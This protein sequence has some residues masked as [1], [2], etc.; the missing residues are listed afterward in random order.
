MSANEYVVIN[1]KRY[2]AMAGVGAETSSGEPAGLFVIADGAIVA[3][4][5][6]GSGTSG[7]PDP[8]LYGDNQ[9]GQDLAGISTG[10]TYHIQGA[11]G[12]KVWTPT[13]ATVKNLYG[14]A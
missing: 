3:A 7:A 1:G 13:G 11:A 8:E 9:I 12:S 4:T 5:W 10:L 14:G 6:A 2:A